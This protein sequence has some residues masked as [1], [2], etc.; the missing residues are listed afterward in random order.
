[1]MIR[2]VNNG[3][4]KIK[5]MKKIC[6]L[7]FAFT[8]LLITSSFCEEKFVFAVIGDTRPPYGSSSFKNFDEQLQRI[9]SFNPAL[10]I[11]LGD[12]IYGYGGQATDAA[13]SA[14]DSIIARFRLPYYQV[15]GNHDIFSMKAQEEYRRQ[16]KKLYYSFDTAGC[17]FVM[18]DNTEN[19]QWGLIGPEQLGW[20]EQDLATAKSKRIFVFMHLPSWEQA[21]VG[22]VHFLIWKNRLHPL[23]RR[24][25]VKAVFAGHVHAYGPTQTID[26]IPY[27]ITGG[28]G[29]E[30]DKHYLAAGGDFHFMLVSDSKDG[31]DWRVVTANAVLDES[32]ASVER[33]RLFAGNQVRTLLLSYEKLLT[34][35]DQNIEVFINNPYDSVLTGKASWVNSG[36]MF[37]LNPGC[38]DLKIPPHKNANLIFSVH[39][40]MNA[41]SM[42]MLKFDVAAGGQR[43]LFTKDLIIRRKYDIPKATVLPVVNGS[44][45]EWTG[46]P[47]ILKEPNSTSPTA[48]VQTTW[49]KQGL[50]IAAR[51][52]HLK[53]TYKST[54]RANS[55]NEALIIGID[56]M[57]N[58]SESNN[59][60]LQ[61]VISRDSL[62]VELYDQA[63]GIH[64]DPVLTGISAAVVNTGD[65][66]VVYELE[67]PAPFLRPL[68]LKK[69]SRFG[70]DFAVMTADSSGGKR[71]LSWTPGIG[72]DGFDESFKS[73]AHFA[74][75]ELR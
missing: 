33:N 43:H 2:S 52:R 75:A 74:E 15:P 8:I 42:P 28:G 70:I 55:I 9:V 61:I 17:H 56:R 36:N 67:F 65:T 41:C 19:A 59:G 3:V 63:H 1:M 20:L 64:L 27:F 44:I 58:R 71:L 51:V 4:L 32:G 39:T 37:S 24:S 46:D 73:Q 48:S 54:R 60:D 6:K 11:N 62:G 57:L 16:F 29:A 69:N 66:A 49:N 34:K 18:L 50:W 45:D 38:V 31:L 7:A 35:N 23:F 40:D 68:L 22:E 53:H 12:L 30:L 10:L 14:Y 72:Y 26:G 25:K 13:W 21:R 47:V 5:M